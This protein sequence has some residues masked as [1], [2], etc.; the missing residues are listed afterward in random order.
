MS[1]VEVKPKA[2]HPKHYCPICD[3]YSM[4]KMGEDHHYKCEVCGVEHAGSYWS[5]PFTNEQ[6][7][8]LFRKM[9]LGEEVMWKYE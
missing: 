5:K 8:R 2:F 6:I 9:S 7:E 4:K 1:E 3:R